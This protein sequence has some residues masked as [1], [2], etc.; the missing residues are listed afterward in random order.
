MLI[1][2]LNSLNRV[3][4]LNIFIPPPAIASSYMLRNNHKGNRKIE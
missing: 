4:Q 3:K 1:H 2:T